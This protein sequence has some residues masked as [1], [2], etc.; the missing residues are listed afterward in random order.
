MSD[1]V[2]LALRLYDLGFNVVPVD[3]NKRPLCPWSSSRRVGREVLEELLDRATGI[4]IVAG[5][6]NP[7]KPVAILVIIDVDR[8]SALERTPMLKTFIE[9]TVHWHTGPRCP[10]CE[11]KH[12]DVIELGRM[13]RCPKCDI[14]FPANEA[15]RGL[16]ALFT[17]SVGDAEMLGGTL[18][19][20]DIEIL[21]NNYQLIP[22]SLHPSGVRYEWVREFDFSSP[23]LGV[24]SLIGAEL[25]LVLDELG[26]STVPAGP[27]PAGARKAGLRELGD[28][29]L[30]KLKELLKDA[31]RPGSRQM[32]LLYLSG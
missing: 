11:E 18:R 27:K 12:L 9:K 25:K 16:G 20:G 28:G 29:D 31:Y 8:P 14:E 10:K 1:L 15:R 13:F 6:E 21:V 24:Y 7:S 30:L 4:A 32:L 5:A 23:N 3:V 22:P 26:S 17:V 19:F 2:E